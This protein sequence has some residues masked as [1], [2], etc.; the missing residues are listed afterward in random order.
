MEN[1]TIDK[2][3]MRIIVLVYGVIVAAVNF[4][5]FM[6]ANV[7]GLPITETEDYL[8]WLTFIEENSKLISLI[9]I[10]DFVVPVILIIQYRFI[11]EKKSSER[12]INLPFVFSVIGSLGWIL[13]FVVE[14][15]CLL[16][17]KGR[18]HIVITEILVRS[19]LNILQVSICIFTLAFLILNFIH[20]KIV[21][22]K[23]F[24]EG[25]LSRFDIGM[26]PSVR[27]IVIVFYLSI[28]VFP[29]FFVTSALIATIKNNQLQMNRTIF[30]V[31]G[32]VMCISIVI[33]WVFCD[34]FTAPLVKLK[35]ATQRIKIGD[36][37]HHVDIVS[38]DDFGELA[39]AF[40]DMTNAIDEKN[41]KI[42]AIQDSIIK[43]MAIMVENRD[44]STGGH[45][46]RT[47]DCVKVFVE[48]LARTEESNVYTAGFCN[49]VIKAAPMHDLGKIAVDDAILRKEKSLEDN[50]YEIMK[51][52]AAK[53]AKIVESVLSQVDD[54]I[55]KNIA[56]N[57]AHYHHEKWNGTGYPEKLSGENIPLEA[58]IMALADVFDALVSK[59]HYK[60]GF[61]Y[62]KAFSII[63]E[64]LGTHFDPVL[65]R[66]FI[67]CRE[68]LERLYDGYK[69][70]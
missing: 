64:S 25:N 53:G 3:K 37:Q 33:L 47:S 54:E 31:L 13:S 14:L 40:N 51:S 2:K 10:M 45:I 26:K 52:H 41:K 9:N 39:D 18:Y 38:S 34:Y 58:R 49:A 35:Q 48:R 43:G 16:Y 67:E 29:V 19:L 5:G 1:I 6:L 66:I 20:R 21:L 55:F 65:G 15:C 7:E 70:Q 11:L 68:E 69:R 59:R 56:I 4:F 28:C 46:S 23:L 63:E 27:F 62:D 36:Y 50:E 8:G 44:N 42:Y 57:V 30:I 24:P 17:V 12:I 22:P 32:L 61:S 60:E